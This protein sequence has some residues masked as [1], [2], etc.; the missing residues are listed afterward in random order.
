MP[1]KNCVPAC[2][3]L[4][5]K[6]EPTREQW[7]EILTAVTDVFSSEFEST[8]LPTLSSFVQQRE[9]SISIHQQLIA[10]GFFFEPGNEGRK[11][12]FYRGVNCDWDESKIRE[13]P[14]V[15]WG[16]S[17]KRKILSVE[18]V[19]GGD[20]SFWY[21]PREVEIGNLLDLPHLSP[22]HMLLSM[23]HEAMRQVLSLE[24]RLAWSKQH[25]E[26]LDRAR[27][28]VNVATAP[29]R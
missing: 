29:A 12:G 21:D 27:E 25:L 19:F 28:V 20:N 16:I 4:I 11:Q 26:F 15:A 1:S 2:N 8:T 10:R 5:P 3:C 23:H 22:R 7:V 14:V 13:I 24:E 17:R 9:A 6:G 18:L